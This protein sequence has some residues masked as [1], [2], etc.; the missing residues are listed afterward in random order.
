VYHRKFQNPKMML[1]DQLLQY[2]VVGDS[3]TNLPAAITPTPKSMVDSQDIGLW[4][5]EA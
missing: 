2:T 3:L 1:E 4:P 5:V